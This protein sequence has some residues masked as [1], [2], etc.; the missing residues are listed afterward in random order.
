MTY[1]E[2]D[3]DVV[4]SKSAAITNKSLTNNVATITTSSAH[5]FAD[6]WTV[7][8]SGVDDVFDGTF[9][10]KEVTSTT[11][12][13]ALVSADV[14]STAV[15]PN[16][17]ATVPAPAYI[18]YQPSDTVLD[19]IASRTDFYAEPWDYNTSRIVWGVDSVVN[20][21][22]LSDIE[23]GLTPLVAI[24]RSAFGYPMTPLDG[25]KIFERKYTDVFSYSGNLNVP[26]AMETQPADPNNDFQRPVASAQS[27]YDRNLTPGKWYYYTLFFYVKGTNSSAQWVSGGS[28]DVLIPFNYKHFETFY[29]LIPPYY[30]LKDSEFTAGTGK[31]GV[32]ERLIRVIGFEAD[33]TRT[34]AEGTE[35][36]YNVDY[37]HDDLL[38]ALGETNMGVDTE[39]GLGDIRYRSLLATINK[40]YDERGSTRG[41]QKLTLASTKYNNKIVEG[42]NMMNLTDDAEFVF[43]TG[44]WGDLVGTQ[45]TFVNSYSWGSTATAWNPI[46]ISTVDDS[47]SPSI[48]KRALYTSYL[49]GNASDGAAAS[50][51]KGLLL[52]CGVGVGEVINRLHMVE[53]VNFYPQF[54]G[55]RCQSGIVYT[56]SFYAKRLGTDAGSTAANVTAGI[57]WFNLP[58]N[59]AFSIT[60]DF[61]SF[62][63]QITST[64]NGADTTS[65]VRYY[66]QAQAPLSL[67]GEGYVFAVPYIAFNNSYKRHVYACMF[68]PQLNSSTNFAVNPDITLTLNAPNELLNSSYLLGDNV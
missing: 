61:I 45:N 39:D 34:L 49:T 11:F 30:R 66:V 3:V 32:L 24:T 31:S 63:K 1:F 14:V 48:R 4:R 53:S 16:G 13:Y 58:A 22:V 7:L 5:S 35:N 20:A 29:D 28:T 25:Q 26:M 43:N 51:S 57:M 68:S 12:T 33:Y 46:D 67:R 21:K 17:L 27:L 15:S 36:I 8:I 37:V 23:A 60:N 38:H 40:L 62:D 6:K 65:L 59:H 10:I 55:I 42:I 54:Y 41:I 9:T 19:S 56:F 44:S 47:N 52:T 64:A 18:R 2:T 50:A